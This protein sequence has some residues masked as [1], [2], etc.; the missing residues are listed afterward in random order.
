MNVAASENFTTKRTN[1]MLAD[2][3]RSCR[4]SSKCQCSVTI[5]SISGSHFLAEVWPCQM[6]YEKPWK[7]LKKGKYKSI[8]M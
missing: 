6:M 8:T 2:R 1:N 7:S 5:V 4:L 3:E